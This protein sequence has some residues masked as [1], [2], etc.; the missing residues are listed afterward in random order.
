MK[1]EKGFAVVMASDV[2]LSRFELGT[3]VC[4]DPERSRDARPPDDRRRESVCTRREGEALLILLSSF[5]LVVSH[6]SLPVYDL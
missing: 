1:H 5:D 2:C 3:S 4:P 6:P